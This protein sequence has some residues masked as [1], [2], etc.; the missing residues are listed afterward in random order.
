M[1]ICDSDIPGLV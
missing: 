1:F